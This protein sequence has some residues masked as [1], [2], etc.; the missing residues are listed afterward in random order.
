MIRLLARQNVNRTV[1]SLATLVS[2]SVDGRKIHPK[3]QG[4]TVAL[5]FWPRCGPTR[6]HQL[7][8]A[9]DCQGTEYH[10]NAE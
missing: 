2:V 8:V 9:D 10:A 3:W 7:L 6:T 1:F 5:P 4:A